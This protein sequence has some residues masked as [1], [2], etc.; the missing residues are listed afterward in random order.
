MKKG[1]REKAKKHDLIKRKKGT[2][3]NKR[4]KMQKLFLTK[5]ITKSD[6]A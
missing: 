5:P 4:K 6:E 2:K 3:R 1:T